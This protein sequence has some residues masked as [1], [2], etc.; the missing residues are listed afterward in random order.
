MHH[1]ESE[2]ESKSLARKRGPVCGLLASMSGKTGHGTQGKPWVVCKFGGTSVSY[3]KSWRQIFVRVKELL[4]EHRVLLVLSAL[5][6]VGFSIRN[7]KDRLKVIFLSRNQSM[8]TNSTT[9]TGYT[10]LC[11]WEFSAQWRPTA[12]IRGIFPY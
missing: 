12:N 2:S 6:Q 10:W 8:G 11:T 4:P 5:T 7:N 1:L 3:N 9:A